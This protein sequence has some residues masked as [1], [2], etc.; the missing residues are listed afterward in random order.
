MIVGRGL[1]ANAFAAFAGDAQVTIFASGVSNSAETRREEFEREE[2]L[3]AAAL[4]QSPGA[5]VYFST[6]S[7]AD[8]ERAASPYV[9]HKLRM[10]RLARTAARHLIFRL[11]QVVGRTDNPHT[12]TNYLH[13][14]VSSGRPFQVW[15]NAWRNVIDVE[16][17]ARIC[18]YMIRQGG[19]WNR[20]VNVASP[21]PVRVTDLVAIFERVLGVRAACEPVELG[22]RYDIDTADAEHAA[23]AI[24]VEF[25]PR[26]EEELIGR[27]YGDKRPA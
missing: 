1:V 20:T 10:E 14:S 2:R 12:L 22:D 25:G 17:A 5:L 27:Y 19:Y 21:R 3:L 23:R 26:Y 8:P 9:V 24:G 11:P 4:A 18:T 7:I 13:R 6:C 16:D 15:K